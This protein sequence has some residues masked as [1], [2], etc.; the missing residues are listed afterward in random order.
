MKRALVSGSSGFIG[1]HLV[2]RL[3]LDGIAVL[4]VDHG[5]LRQKDLTKKIKLF[6]PNLIIH[7]SAYG[8]LS[9]QTDEDEI[10]QANI[11]DLYTLLQASKTIS[12][13]TFVNFSSSS[14]LLPA[15]TL[16]SAT[17][18][19]G[20]RLCKYFGSKYQ[21]NIISVQPYT[22]IGVGESP[23]HLIPTL[24]RSCLK[25]EKMDFVGEPTHDFISVDDFID[26]LKLII[27]DYHL[28]GN[29]EIGTGL[30]TANEEVLEIVEELTGNKANIQR[31]PQMRSY[32]SNNWKANNIIIKSLGWVQRQTLREVI[33]LMC[34]K[35]RKDLKDKS[36]T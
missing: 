14:T 19:A 33:E 26:A 10:I 36:K 30:A 28:K 22:V 9:D 3:L 5:E 34:D 31:V 1:S 6:N 25:A 21:K 35:Y 12:Y 4:P 2:R 11:N 23:K 16:Y 27:Q 17:K 32:D 13:D 7:T 20:E 8:N 15:E 29:V 18:G 24:I